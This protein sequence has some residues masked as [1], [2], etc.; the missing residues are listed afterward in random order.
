MAQNVSYSNN[1]TLLESLVLHTLPDFG[2]NGDGII[3]NN[4]LLSYLKSNGRQDIVEGGLEFWSGVIKGENSNFKWQ[5]HEDT[6]TAS[7]QDPLDRLRFPIKTFTG[8]QVINKLHEA[9]NK[10]RAMVKDWAR[11]LVQQADSTIKNSFNS[12]FWAA[13]PGTDE[14]ESVPSLIS[15]TPTTGTIGGMNRAGNKHLQNTAYTTAVADIGSEA[16]I[17]AVNRQKIRASITA[18]DQPDLMIMDEELYSGMVGY[19]ANLQRYR[20]NDT[21]TNLGFDTIKLGQATYS[22]ENTNVSGTN[23]SITGGYV[24]GINSNYFAFKLLRD[25]NFKWADKFERVGQTLNKALYFWA[26]CNLTTNLPK[27]HFVMTN[28]S[29]T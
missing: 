8:A 28:V 2:K 16:G 20:P 15:A 9:Q 13:T 3:N 21:M 1:D 18:N 27:A 10:G 6:M 7:L 11:T 23:N 12:A 25:G 4:L 19:L 5:G 22:Y 29:T 26:F 17:A 24:Y 14:P